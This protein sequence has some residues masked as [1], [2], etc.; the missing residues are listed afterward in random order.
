MLSHLYFD[1]DWAARHSQILFSF[2]FVFGEFSLMIYDFVWNKF[3]HDD[4]QLH[5]EISIAVTV[6]MDHV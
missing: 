1:A 3:I 5:D 6:N 4:A 2:F